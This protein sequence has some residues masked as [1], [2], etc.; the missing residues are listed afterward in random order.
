MNE[1]SKVARK[2]RHP[3]QVAD[4]SEMI[5]G[6][7]YAFVTITSRVLDRLWAGR[8]VFGGAFS[9]YLAA[10]CLRG[11]NPRLARRLEVYRAATA[12]GPRPRLARRLEVGMLTDFT[13]DTDVASGIPPADIVTIHTDGIRNPNDLDSTIDATTIMYWRADG[14]SSWDLLETFLSGGPTTRRHCLIVPEPEWDA[15]PHVHVLDWVNPD[16][17]VERATA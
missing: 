10:I 7:S 13:G 6:H 3:H 17:V 4:V 1:T 11:H 12:R 14:T 9:D 5:P 8:Y 16:D 15:D 2:V